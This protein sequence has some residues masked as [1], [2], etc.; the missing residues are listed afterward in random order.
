MVVSNELISGLSGYISIV[1]WIV[2]FT[3]Q[4]YTNYVRKSGEA[5]SLLFV[6][7]WLTGDIFN[8]IGAVFQGVMPTMLAL[9][10]YYAFADTTL[11]WQVLYYRHQLDEEEA[12]EEV[13]EQ[14]I[15]EYEHE[16]SRDSLIQSTSSLQPPPSPS[17]KFGPTESRELRRSRSYSQGLRHSRSYSQGVRRLGHDGRDIDE[18]TLLIRHPS[19]TGEGKIHTTPRWFKILYDI[20][21]IIVV[22]LVG[23]LLY[24]VS[25]LLSNNT[26]KS[27]QVPDDELVFDPVGQFFGWGCAFLYLG[28]RLPQIIKNWQS[29]ST[30]GLAILFFM[31]SVLGN[32]TYVI[33]ILAGSTGYRY[34]AIH[35]SWVLGSAGTLVLDFI[36]F[37]QFWIYQ[38]K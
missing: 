26:S 17:T 27:P 33:S 14:A 10:I 35:A 2:V 18:T 4:I 5:L 36:I 24:F 37:I 21:C 7:I 11:L 9:A 6:I 32:V 28:S 23:I 1:S 31:F 20:A 22:I 29:Q 34:L 30:E 19:P 3:P 8:I 15:E 25:Q 13:I 12:D 38:I 16:Y